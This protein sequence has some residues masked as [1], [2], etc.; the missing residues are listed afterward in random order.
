[1]NQAEGYVEDLLK[2]G[3]F[4]GPPRVS[5]FVVGNSVSDRLT[6]VRRVAD[7]E[8]GR[9]EAVSIGQLVRTANIR[10]FRVRD[11]V[12]ERYPDT[13]LKLVSW[14]QDRPEQL[15]LLGL[16]RE[17]P[18]KAQGTAEDGPPVQ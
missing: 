13:G 15:D 6:P 1:M 2:C 3:L 12:Q 17:A 14:L 4:D 7:P 10:L 8:V 16:T 9:I 5:S 11:Q 18:K